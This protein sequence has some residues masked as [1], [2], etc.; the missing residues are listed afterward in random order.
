MTFSEIR[1]VKSLP[2]N[3]GISMRQLSDVL[4][5]PLPTATHLVSRLVE[6]GVV[7]R[8]R[9]EYDRRVVLVELSE[10]LKTHRQALYDKRVELLERIIQPLA[11]EVRDQILLTFNAIAESASTQAEVMRASAARSGQV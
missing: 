7:V 4:G 5:V 6:K 3:G 11:P 1:A 2:D 9:P 10:R 8:V